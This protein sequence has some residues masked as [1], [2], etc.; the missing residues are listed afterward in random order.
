VAA[1]R[2]GAPFPRYLRR[3]GGSGRDKDDGADEGAESAEFKEVAEDVAQHVRPLRSSS[4]S[5]LYTFCSKFPTE[6]YRMVN[7]QNGAP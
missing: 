7:P 5:L 1:A 4:V 3:G 6:P 2:P